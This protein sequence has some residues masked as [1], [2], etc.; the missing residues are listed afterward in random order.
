L[1]GVGQVIA[2]FFRGFD[3][4]EELEEFLRNLFQ[5]GKNIFSAV[6]G[7]EDIQVIAAVSDLE[8]LADFRRPVVMPADLIQYA[9]SLHGSLPVRG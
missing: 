7:I 2:V 5:Y 4:L 1:P 3:N 8:F 6:S 9:Q